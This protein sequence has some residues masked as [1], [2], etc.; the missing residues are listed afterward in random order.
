MPI[1]FT[2]DDDGNPTWDRSYKDNLTPQEATIIATM[3]A[4]NMLRYISDSIDT[5]SEA[6]IEAGRRAGSAN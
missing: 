5:L 4:A 2:L 3:Q 1:T 6:V